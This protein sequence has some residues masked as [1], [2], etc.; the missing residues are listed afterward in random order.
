MLMRVDSISL[1]DLS[2]LISIITPVILLVWFYYTQR[3]SLSKI[4]FE[5]ISGIY[6]G[7]TEPVSSKAEQER[8]GKIYAGMVMNIR[9]V[10]TNGY[11]KGE[12][13]FSER[14][15]FVENDI[16]KSKMLR[17]AMH[18][19]YGNMKYG[20]QWDKKRNPFKL[21]ENR[22]YLGTLYIMTRLDILTEGNNLQKYVQAE[23]AITHY[24]EMEIMKLEL[25]K[26]YEKH[27]LLLPSSF[28]LHKSS[29]FE[30]EPYRF[31]KDM[32]FNKKTRVDK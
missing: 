5:E 28:T 13:D 25:K 7:F 11:F 29:G 3:Q 32:V 1:E 26:K 22:T 16:P 18:I 10:N 2:N 24:R 12:L 17:D 8:L 19:F 15:N 4:Y 23:Y 9:E 21:E 31:V 6:A 14:T 27:S 30:F 20:F